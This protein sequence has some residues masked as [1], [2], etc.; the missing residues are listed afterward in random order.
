MVVTSELRKAFAPMAVTVLGI[1]TDVS[2]PVYPIKTVFKASEYIKSPSKKALIQYAPHGLPDA[3][4]LYETFL[5]DANALYPMLI[6]EFGTDR[7]EI[8]VQLAK[9]QLPMCITELLIVTEEIEEQPLK[10]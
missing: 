5:I 2:E 3:V 7:D 4:P 1:V 8:P 6:T 10:A 9:A